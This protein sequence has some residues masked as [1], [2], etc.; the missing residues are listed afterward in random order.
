MFVN[1]VKL[2]P[3]A[4]SRSPPLVGPFAALARPP[5]LEPCNIGPLCYI[6]TR[7]PALHGLQPKTGVQGTAAMLRLDLTPRPSDGTLNVRYNG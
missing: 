2:A 1:L 7:T 3:V 6:G 5:A 4:L